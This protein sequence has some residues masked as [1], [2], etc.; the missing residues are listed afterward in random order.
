M[1]EEFGRIL[2]VIQ[3]VE[4]TKQYDYAC[5]FDDVNEHREQAAMLSCRHGKVPKYHH[6]GYSNDKRKDNPESAG[7]RDVSDMVLSKSIGRI[8]QAVFVCHTDEQRHACYHSYKR[9]QCINHSEED[10][11]LERNTEILRFFT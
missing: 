11:D 3:V 7:M 1:I 2:Q 5:C 8:I 6:D 9:N 4:Y 10:S